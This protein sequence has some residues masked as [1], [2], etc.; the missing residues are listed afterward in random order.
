MNKKTNGVYVNLVMN[1][2]QNVNNY[3][4]QCLGLHNKARRTQ[5]IIQIFHYLPKDRQTSPLDPS[6]HEN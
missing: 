2:H 6:S 5:S 4:I 3:P 1:P